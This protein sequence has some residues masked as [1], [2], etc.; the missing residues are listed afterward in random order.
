MK[1]NLLIVIGLGLALVAAGAARLLASGQRQAMAPRA[2]ATTGS[3]TATLGQLNSFALGLLLGGL[4]GPLV[5]ALWSSSESQKTQQ[6]LEDF[7]TRVELI[8]LLQPQFDSVHL[9]Q[10]WNKA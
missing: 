8:R 10:I 9:Y 1:N 6:D 2:L 3:S 5:M 4:R 7:D